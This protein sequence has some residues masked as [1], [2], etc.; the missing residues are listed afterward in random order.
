MI[1]RDG[2]VYLLA[3]RQ[4]VIK[5]V[6][7]PASF[8]YRKVGLS[9][10][11]CHESKGCQLDTL[12]LFNL[13]CYSFRYFLNHLISLCCCLAVSYFDALVCILSYT[14]RITDSGMCSDAYPRLCICSGRSTTITPSSS[15]NKSRTKRADRR[16]SA[17][18]STGV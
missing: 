11:I 14:R 8:V 4:K 10:P 16:Q 6:P 2:T 5:R 18:I 1:K 13:C 9:V 3:T 7:Q 12:G 15:L 17:P